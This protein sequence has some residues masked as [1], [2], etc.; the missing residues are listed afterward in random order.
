MIHKGL[1]KD[2]RDPPAGTGCNGN[3]DL[4]RRA[5]FWDVWQHY[6]PIT[7]QLQQSSSSPLHSGQHTEIWHKKTFPGM[8]NLN[9]PW[10]GW[11]IWTG[12]VKFERAILQ[13]FKCPGDCPGWWVLK[14]RT[15]RRIK[16]WL[17][18]LSLQITVLAS[19][20]V[21]RSEILLR[22]FRCENVWGPWR[23]GPQLLDK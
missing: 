4:E 16:L 23:N 19:S 21:I 6:V 22:L 14:L 11:E 1:F 3:F 13:K 7:S 5:R 17:K 9:L 20:E 8:G 18:L 15:D 12:S 2:C 10:V